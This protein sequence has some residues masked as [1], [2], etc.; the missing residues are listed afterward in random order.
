MLAS[1]E[2]A[3]VL[4]KARRMVRL[5]WACVVAA[6]GFLV[7]QVVFGGWWWGAS[8]ACAVVVVLLRLSTSGM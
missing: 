7:L 4:D 8:I 2:K 5:Q 3:R 1:S 6:C